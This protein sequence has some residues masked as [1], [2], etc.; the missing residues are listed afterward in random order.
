MRQFVAAAAC[1]ALMA[2]GGAAEQEAATPDETA[3]ATPSPTASTSEDGKAAPAAAKAVKLTTTGLTAG[4][5]AFLFEAGRNEV[6]AALKPLLGDPTDRGP[7]EECGAGPMDFTDYAGGVTVNFQDGKLVGWNWRSPQDGDQP[8]KVDITVAGPAQLGTPRASVE[9]ASGFAMFEESTL[10]D[11]FQ[12][13]DNLF[14]F[15]EAGK[16][17]M[18]Y[19]GTQCF[20]R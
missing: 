3:T 15:F 12:I 13:N 11:E 1:L 17:S 19:S 16:V 10:G 20:F 2:C 14:G 7:M 5:E 4:S 9:A 8:A 6:E 18:L